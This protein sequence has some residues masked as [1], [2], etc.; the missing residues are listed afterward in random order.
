MCQGGHTRV[1]LDGWW[2]LSDRLSRPQLNRTGT[3]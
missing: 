2:Q 3:L 1:W